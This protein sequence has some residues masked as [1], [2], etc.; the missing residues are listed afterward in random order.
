LEKLD[1]GV[2][3]CEFTLSNFGASKRQQ[4]AISPL[5]QSTSYYP[6][7]AVGNLDSSSKFIFHLK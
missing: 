5:S 6:L 2:A 7:I 3:D 4:R 1:N